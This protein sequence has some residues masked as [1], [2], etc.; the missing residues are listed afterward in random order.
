VNLT[1]NPTDVVISTNIQEIKIH[2]GFL[3]LYA[4]PDE[5]L[6]DI[7]IYQIRSILI[8]GSHLNIPAGLIKICSE[9]KIPIHILTNLHKHYGSLHFTTD[10]LVLNRQSQYKALIDDKWRLYL[11]KQILYQKIGMQ[12]K[13]AELWGYPTA[14]ELIHKSLMKVN[15][16]THFQGLMG[17]EGQAAI[18]YWQVFGLKLRQVTTDFAW[19]GRQK[20]PTTD[21]VNS[22][23]SLAYG[24]LATQCQT[25]LTLEGLDP[26]LGILHKTNPDRPALTYDIMEAY[27]CL[28]VDLWILGL[29]ENKIFNQK[30]FT[31]TKEGI[32]T[33]LPHPKNEFFK[34]WFKRFKHYQFT[35]NYGQ[36]TLHQFLTSN[37]KLLL[38]WFRKIEDHKERDTSRF[39]RLPEHLIVFQKIDEF[40]FIE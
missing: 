22:L 28:V 35:T 38:E 17:A 2:A 4:E 11:A 37:T 8:E 18:N 19:Q 29:F 39:D 30:D 6:S 13:M 26:Y 16:K 31:T 23:L 15:T 14:V 21:P 33:L 36:I 34:L 20:H 5:I 3:R 7:P 40:G 27:R 10:D 9:H 12:A 32:C 24:L 25:S 1:Q